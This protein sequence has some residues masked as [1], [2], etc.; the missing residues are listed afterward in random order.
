MIA[1]P[2][3]LNLNP[4]DSFLRIKLKCPQRSPIFAGNLSHLIKFVFPL[5][6]SCECLIR[7]QNCKESKPQG[8]HFLQYVQSELTFFFLF[9]CYNYVLK[10]VSFVLGV[11]NLINMTIQLQIGVDSFH[12]WQNSIFI[13]LNNGLTMVV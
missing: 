7:T 9:I 6:A 13:N 11:E 5:F 8:F 12:K 10:F 1:N 4:T 2:H 3:A